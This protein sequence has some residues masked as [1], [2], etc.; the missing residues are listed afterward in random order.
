MAI[1]SVSVDI[2]TTAAADV[3]FEAL[4]PV[5]QPLHGMGGIFMEPEREQPKPHVS[6]QAFGVDLVTMSLQKPPK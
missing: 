5:P 2:S 3:D 6:V 4:L 1:D